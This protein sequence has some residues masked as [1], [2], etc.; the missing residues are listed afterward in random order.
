MPC[1][2][3]AAT[4]VAV[5][6]R[7]E[8]RRAG[9]K[10]WTPARLDEVLCY[11]DHLRTGADGDV[12]WRT[13]DGNEQR[14]R[15]RHG[16]H[17]EFTPPDEEKSVILSLWEGL[18]L[19]L[20]RDSRELDIR[21]RHANG[22]PEGTEFVVIADDN[23]TGFE[24]VDGAV[25]VSS[26]AGT[27]RVAAGETLRVEPDGIVGPA[28]AAPALLPWAYFPRIVAGPLPP[29]DAEPPDA[30][31]ADFFV[32]RA[33]ALLEVGAAA[34]ALADLDRAAAIDANDARIDALRAIVAQSAGD[35]A[36]AEAFAASALRTNGN[37]VEALL[38]SSHVR[39]TSDSASRDA[40]A[41][42]VRLALRARE[43][44]R[45]NGLAWTRLAEAYLAIERYADAAQTAL[46]A[47]TQIAPD[48][49][50][51]HTA[52]GFARYAQR[53]LDRA[54]AAF[55]RARQLGSMAPHVWHG[56]ALVLWQQGRRDEAREA[57]EVALILDLGGVDARSALAK[58]YDAESRRML[59]DEQL[60]LAA[61]LTPDDPT[62]LLIRSYVDQSHSNPIAAL[63]AYREAT[64]R[65]GGLPPT[66]STFA[67]DPDQATEAF[68]WS[69]MFID[70]DTPALGN[71]VL[72]RQFA[73]N[74]LS[75]SALQMGADLAAIESFGQPTADGDSWLHTL[76][77]ASIETP[78]SAQRDQELS[79]QIRNAAPRVVTTSDVD[80]PLNE[81]GAEASI[82]ALN[83]NRGNEGI[84]A[85]FAFREERRA[86]GL[87]LFDNRSDGY[88]PNQD[89]A[90]TGG[91]L[92][93]KLAQDPGSNIVA[94][95]R[96]FESEKGDTVYRFFRD[97]YGQSLRFSE[98][99]NSIR[100]GGRKD[101]VGIGEARPE[102]K[103]TGI[104]SVVATHSD[105]RIDSGP[106]A[107]A[108]SL[109][110]QTLAARHV[111]QTGSYTLDV[112]ASFD[113]ATIAQRTGAA[114]AERFREEKRVL[115]AYV[116]H[117]PSEALTL[118]FGVNLDDSEARGFDDLTVNGKAGIVWQPTGRTAWRLAY[119]ETP[120]PPVASTTRSNGQPDLERSRIV[121]FK[122]QTY[123]SADSTRTRSTAVEHEFSATVFGG[124]EARERSRSRPL[125]LN[126]TETYFL[127]IDEQVA[128]AH[129]YWLPSDAVNLA[130]VFERDTY[131]Q[132]PGFGDYTRFSTKRMTIDVNLF[133]RDGFSASLRAAR[134]RQEGS[135]IVA[136]SPGVDYARGTSSFT[137]L[138]AGLSYRLPSRRM[139]VDL[140]LD[141]L[142]DERFN[143][144]E[145]EYDYLTF[146]PARTL[147]LS[148]HYQWR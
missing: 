12:V 124:I 86:F 87:G 140:R 125:S 137:T 128:S 79:P 61:R 84:S 101:T 98:D 3:P 114:P 89:T 118:T 14:L 116:D 99:T 48:L 40:R 63:R 105:Y 68:G 33:A 92:R 10:T 46:Q 117:R 39:Q 107:I 35:Q 34:D 28:S 65:N 123:P 134:V 17:V 115:Y 121:G 80:L 146:A 81:D 69:R 9:S 130:A 120:A 83:G 5:S 16:G 82:S 15:H 129:L 74:P 95:L 108:V 145:P 72:W 57:A 18:M 97:S 111:L 104:F 21:T 147:N 127:E 50:E 60:A 20:S 8:V 139:I 71:A 11:R 106:V 143:Y 56:L 148:F 1:A 112:G 32:R 144:Q 22:G 38:A 73:D 23:G 135:F 94:D 37:S 42:A 138:D 26:P 6:G 76:S 131:A 51:A 90:E 53:R 136:S 64:L 41:E 55:E 113:F 109:R 44:D 78:R 70:T 110:E 133:M 36:G 103:G 30:D 4:I 24:M 58:F 27:R 122:Q 96:W 19:V 66:R 141:N 59:T 25:L 88:R 52:L 102:R 100:I 7:V 45:S 31:Q 29:P 62:P 126:G 43:L 85:S 2:G 91:N 67:L 47:T 13:P 77:T 119:A 75:P 49:A 132:P 93:L 142:T 54:L